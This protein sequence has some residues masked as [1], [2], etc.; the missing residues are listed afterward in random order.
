VNEEG[1]DPREFELVDR[2]SEGGVWPT[3][4]HTPTAF[5]FT[6]IETQDA[7]FR[8]TFMPGETTWRESYG[9]GSW[10]QVIATRLPMWLRYVRREIEA[11]DL[12]GELRREAELVAGDLNAADNTPFSPDE[13]AQVRRH[14]DEVKQLIRA[15]QALTATQLDAID[16]RIDYLAEAT[17]RLGRIDWREA[18]VGSMLGLVVQSVVPPQPIREVMFFVLRAVGHMFGFHLPAIG[19]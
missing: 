13:Q 16:S 10:D 12:W 9:N 17:E 5:S 7:R 6:I 15:N 1:F 3:L 19:K 18:F 4:M 2:Q 11:P 14:L 8:V